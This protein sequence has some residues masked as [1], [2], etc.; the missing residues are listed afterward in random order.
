MATA[1]LRA[2]KPKN[3]TTTLSVVNDVTEVVF[4]ADV[5]PQGGGPTPTGAVTFKDGGTTI[6][7]AQLGNQF[8]MTTSPGTVTAY[9]GGD[10]QYL[11][12]NSQTIS[13]PFG[14]E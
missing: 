7:V 10:K 6:G 8:T 11:P 1:D 4:R 2:P 14:R 5:Q 3:S 12:S 9:Y 13:A